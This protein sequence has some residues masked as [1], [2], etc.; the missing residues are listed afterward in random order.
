MAF[1]GGQ[2]RNEV[3]KIIYLGPGKIHGK[4]EKDNRE[5][6]NV[7]PFPFYQVDEFQMAESRDQGLFIAMVGKHKSDDFSNYR[8]PIDLS[9]MPFAGQPAGRAGDY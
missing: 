8:F 1:G 5:N 6:E 4:Q 3:V 7:M 9:A 2:G